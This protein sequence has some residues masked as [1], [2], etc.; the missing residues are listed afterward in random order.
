M[1]KNFFT[2]K[3]KRMEKTLY[4]DGLLYSYDD[5]RQKWLLSFCTLLISI[6]ENILIMVYLFSTYLAIGT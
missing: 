6:L 3:K 5:G 2:G 1:N 4:H